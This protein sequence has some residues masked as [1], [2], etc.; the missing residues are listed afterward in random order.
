MSNPYIKCPV[1]ETQ[2]FILRLVSEDDAEALLACYSDPKAQALFNVDNFPTDCRFSTTEEMLKY[3][4]FWLVEYEEEAYV[5]FAIVDKSIHKAVGTVEMFGMVGKYKVDTGIL[6]IDLASM[7][8]EKPYLQEIFG[9]CIENFYDLFMVDSIVTKAIK[10]AA[11]R[12]E[13]LDELGFCESEFNGRKH[14]Y[15]HSPR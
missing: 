13:V 7:Y 2:N 9:V 6:R 10:Q 3:I 11:N 5:R 4:K 14:Y 1:L 15:R 8:E 12:I